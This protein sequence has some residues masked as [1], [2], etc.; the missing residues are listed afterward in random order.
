MAQDKLYILSDIERSWKLFQWFPFPDDAGLPVNGVELALLDADAA[1][2][3][4]VYLSSHGQLDSDRVEILT[5][6]S[7]DLDIVL[8]HLDGSRANYFR[9]LKQLCHMVL[10]SVSR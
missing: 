5:R 6:C 7:H 3:I 10:R 9:A 4:K 2:C 8:D 1:G